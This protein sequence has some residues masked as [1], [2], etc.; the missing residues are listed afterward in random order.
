M[1]RDELRPVIPAY[2]GIHLLCA[3]WTPATGRRLQTCATA[4]NSLGQGETS[5]RLPA[6]SV[7]A[8]LSA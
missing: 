1:E 3:L 7:S 4:V 6:A 2:A 8:S 5:G